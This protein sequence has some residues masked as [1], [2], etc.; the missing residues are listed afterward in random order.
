MEGYKFVK[1]RSGN[2]FNL[3]DISH[4]FTPRD[5]DDDFFINFNFGET[6]HCNISKED[7]EDLLE[8]MGLK[9]KK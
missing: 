4:I 9:A 8:A 3:C 7:Y 2:V 1:C 5:K 6:S